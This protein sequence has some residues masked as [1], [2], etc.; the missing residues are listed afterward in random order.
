MNL[1][2]PAATRSLEKARIAPSNL[3]EEGR[4][5]IS[6]ALSP[7]SRQVQAENCDDLTP[8]HILASEGGPALEGIGPVSGDNRPVGDLARNL[9][10]SA[11]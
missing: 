6:E 10:L 8:A 11:C 9:Y 1:E 7:S 5:G 2:A 4:V 3:T